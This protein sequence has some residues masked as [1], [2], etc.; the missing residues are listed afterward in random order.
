MVNIKFE[1]NY[2]AIF[3]L[4]M[5]FIHDFLHDFNIVNF[6][7]RL[8]SIRGIIAD[9][10]SIVSGETPLRPISSEDADMEEEGDE[11]QEEEDLGAF[12]F[13]DVSPP[14]SPIPVA[15]GR[16]ALP[17]PSVPVRGR[18]RAREASPET[19][20]APRGRRRTSRSSQIGG[21]GYNTILTNVSHYQGFGVGGPVEQLK[22]WAKKEGKNMNKFLPTDKVTLFHVKI[23]QDIIKIVDESQLHVL[24]FVGHKT[25]PNQKGGRDKIV[26]ETHRN[27]L[28]MTDNVHRKTSKNENLTH[29]R[30]HNLGKYDSHHDYV[31][32]GYNTAIEKTHG[33]TRDYFTFMKKLFLCYE[34]TDKNPYET[35]TNV[36]IKHALILYLLN[37]DNRLFNKAKPYELLKSLESNYRGYFE[38]VLSTNTSTGKKTLGLFKGGDPNVF[39]ATVKRDFSK[40][41]P[42]F[43]NPAKTNEDL[44]RSVEQT[45]EE[46]DRIKALIDS[47]ITSSL[48]E[49]LE[50]K[51]ILNPGS[52]T[53]RKVYTDLVNDY[54][55][56]K[57]SPSGRISSTKK[58]AFLTHTK[59]LIVYVCDSINTHNIALTASAAAEAARA[60]SGSLTQPQRDNIG[61]ISVIVAEGGKQ[62]IIGRSVNFAL[63]NDEAK[64][65]TAYNNNSVL[66]TEC[67]IIDSVVKK[68]EVPGT[69]DKEIKKSFIKYADTNF[70]NRILKTPAQMVSLIRVKR[71]QKKIVSA[72]NNAT[73]K[74]LDLLQIVESERKCPLSSITDAQG[75]F[76]SCVNSI[77]T[78]KKEYYPMDFK[79]TNRDESIYYKGETSFTQRGSKI[80]STVSFSAKIGDFVLEP[81]VL[82][83][84]I[85]ENKSFLGLSANTTISKVIKKIVNIWS[86]LFGERPESITDK[87]MWQELINTPTVFAD[88]ISCTA[89][90]SVGDLFQEI[91]SVAKN[92]GY[93][94]TTGG[95]CTQCIPT[96]YFNNIF[97]IG[98]NGDQPSGVRAGFILLKAT[99]DSLIPDAMAG[100]LSVKK[101]RSGFNDG[102]FVII[103]ANNVGGRGGTRKIGGAKQT[104]RKT[105]KYY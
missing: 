82:E 62:H 22:F 105:R 33:K 73:T 66:R 34:D 83:L 8:S 64:F 44:Y 17:E 75:S 24:G 101:D 74:S 13:P 94:T 102:S 87:R 76:G 65:N 86:R 92:G 48:S 21:G 26:V 58:K 89:I 100:Y 71:T 23:M 98:A 60:S 103:T 3:M 90:K 37:E 16:T 43:D 9:F 77:T 61:M 59:D 57:N 85:I 40:F 68:R 46:I 2:D 31:K 30:V 20:V 88:L 81:S 28:I 53:Y 49:D 99:P 29:N 47:D 27:E 5:I 78:E 55:A 79:I 95:R 19:G 93:L 96:T 4:I 72:I 51:A 6:S 63:V 69:I 45:D 54:T 25:N 1:N 38:N 10:T 36:H 35:F 67:K 32:N 7:D 39:L 50:L 18:V 41:V 52:E 15:R 104:N 91:N 84:E 97:R 70:R 12:F 56:Y 80:N 42:F 14:A 11:E